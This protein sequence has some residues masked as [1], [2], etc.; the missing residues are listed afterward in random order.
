MF[1]LGCK[2]IK[3]VQVDDETFSVYGKKGVTQLF[4]SIPNFESDEAT[5]LNKLGNS[6]AQKGDFKSARETFLKAI[7]IEP[8]ND[9][10]WANLGL[11][12]LFLKNYDE[13]ISHLKKAINID[14]TNVSHYMNLGV[15]YNHSKQYQKALEINLFILENGS[16]PSLIGYVYLNLAD[17]YQNLEKC[18]K[19]KEAL[20]MGK[21]IIGEK[22]YEIVQDFEDLEKDVKNCSSK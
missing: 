9:W 6:Q 5:N 4:S 8:N 17:D 19:A 21:G 20:E 2:P 18:K 1:C 16:D 22:V 3:T 14:K 15:V 10:L 12:E 11:S 7:K 13:S